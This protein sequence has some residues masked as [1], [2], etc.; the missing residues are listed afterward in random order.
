MKKAGIWLFYALVWEMAAL[1]VHRA[2]ILPSFSSVITLMFSQLFSPVLFVSL[3]ISLIRVLIGTMIAL[4]LALITSLLVESYPV[5]K[6]WFRPL[7]LVSKTI[8]NITYILIILIWFSRE[9]TV[10]IITLLILFPVLYSHLSTAI[11]TILPEYNDL[12]QL[13]PENYFHRL[14]KVILPL[15]KPQSLWDLKSGSWLNS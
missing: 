6:P 3:G 8:P 9:M 14:I 12:R 4:T 7:V 5:L 11:E 13:F 1:M 10:S 15:I 2:I